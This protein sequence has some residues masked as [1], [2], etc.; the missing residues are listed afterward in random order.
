MAGEIF[1]HIFNKDP[2]E[3]KSIA[4]VGSFVKNK[5]GHEIKIEQIDTNLC[6]SR[7]SIFPIKKTDAGETMDKVIKK[8]KS[9]SRQAPQKSV[10]P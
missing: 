4:E 2:N 10:C 5:T 1:Q 8:H 7:G 9:H 3:F 6:S